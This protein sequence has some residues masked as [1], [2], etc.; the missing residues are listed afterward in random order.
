VEQVRQSKV[1]QLETAQ[2]DLA[3]FRS[4]VRTAKYDARLAVGGQNTQLA[5]QCEG[6]LA[7]INELVDTQLPGNT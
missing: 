4:R 1:G 7:V 3:L 2:A 6:L 5:P